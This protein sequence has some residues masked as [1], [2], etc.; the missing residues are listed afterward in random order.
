M[1]LLKTCGQGGDGNDYR[2]AF[3][4]IISSG[5]WKRIWIVQEIMLAR[6]VILCYGSECVDWD[7]WAQC[8]SMFA[9]HP[10]YSTPAERIYLWK[11]SWPKRPKMT[12]AQALH[13]LL[14]LFHDMESSDVR[15]KMYGLCGL[16][17]RMYSD[18]GGGRVNIDYSLAPSV[19]IAD[20]CRHFS[21]RFR[22]PFDARAAHVLFDLID[23]LAATLRIPA[24]SRRELIA[25][26]EALWRTECPGTRIPLTDTV[27]PKMTWEDAVLQEYDE[28]S[29][30]IRL[31]RLRYGDPGE[32]PC[33]SDIK[34]IWPSPKCWNI[35]PG[36][37]KALGSVDVEE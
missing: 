2:K 21:R 22:R 16:L 18:R 10:P 35:R 13:S 12:K 3:E 14:D 20:V 30:Q 27:L 19:L 15:D 25:Y 5:Y 23:R 33:R 26:H 28:E 31:L 34:N 32:M 24:D 29:R 11:S 8:A 6:R 7:S 9:R 17:E 36:S 37:E 1:S 4:E